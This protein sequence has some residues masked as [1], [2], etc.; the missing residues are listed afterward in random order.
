VHSASLAGYLSPNLTALTLL[1]L[2]FYGL[3]PSVCHFL[4]SWK[5]VDGPPTCSF[6]YLSWAP[7]G[8]RFN[9]E[10][11]AIGNYHSTKIWSFSMRTPCCS[12]RIEIHTDPKN[13]RYKI[14]SGAKQK[15]RTL[16][17]GWCVSVVA[18]KASQDQE[19]NGCPPPP[20]PRQAQQSPKSKYNKTAMNNAYIFGA[21]LRC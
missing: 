17:I 6:V 20:P 1:C 7:Q 13:A 16:S 3:L 11:K 15:V 8:V 2:F 19:G 4:R 9:A 18:G 21:V 14:V 12:T 10:K 5:G